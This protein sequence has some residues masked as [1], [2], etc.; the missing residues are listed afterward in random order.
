MIFR[1]RTFPLA[2]WQSWTLSVNNSPRTNDANSR[3]EISPRDTLHGRR[4]RRSSPISRS[5]PPMMVERA[6]ESHEVKGL[7]PP[8][9]ALSP[10]DACQVGTKSRL[11]VSLAVSSRG[12]ASRQPRCSRSV[13]CDGRRWRTHAKRSFI[14]FLVSLGKRNGREWHGRRH[15]ELSNARFNALETHSWRTSWMN[16]RRG[17]CSISQKEPRKAARACSHSNE[18]FTIHFLRRDG[19]SYS[20]CKNVVNSGEVTTR[21]SSLRNLGR[22]FASENWQNS[23]DCR[24]ENVR[25]VSSFRCCSAK[26]PEN[27][28]ERKATKGWIFTFQ[29][30]RRCPRIQP[31]MVGKIRRVHSPPTTNPRRTLFSQPATLFL[32]STAALFPA[33][34]FIGERSSKRRTHTRT[35]TLYTRLNFHLHFG[36][37]SALKS[38]HFTFTRRRTIFPL[39]QREIT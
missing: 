18:F 1:P 2:A 36:T 32:A 13:N 14:Y 35:Y 29:I 21:T 17:F 5:E 9:D 19:D 11:A 22:F 3:E 28:S 39:I 4:C 20:E 24:A 25:C 23:S 12:A 34:K 15:T 7:I 38:R 30:Y 8:R 6:E 10:R 33:E 31:S 26:G 16:V 37:G 27:P